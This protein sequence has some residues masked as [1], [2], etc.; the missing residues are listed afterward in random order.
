MKLNRRLGKKIHKADCNEHGTITYASTY[1]EEWCQST[2]VERC[3][4]FIF[5]DLRCTVEGTCVLFGSLQTDF[6]NIFITDS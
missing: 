1:P 3:W 6:D 5:P 4:T 2:L